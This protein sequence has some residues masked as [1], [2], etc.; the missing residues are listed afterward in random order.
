M[1]LAP[2]W[3]MAELSKRNIS[4]TGQLRL[5][6]GGVRR[7]LAHDPSQQ[8]SSILPRITRRKS[9]SSRANR[10]FLSSAMFVPRHDS[11]GIAALAGGELADIQ[12]LASS[13]WLRFFS[14]IKITNLP[15]SLASDRCGSRCT[16]RASPLTFPSHLI[17][18]PKCHP[19]T[20]L[21]DRRPWASDSDLDANAAELREA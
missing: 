4:L 14:A 11:S 17:R 8:L 2:L 16:S 12:T 15:L 3:L 5:T 19:R 21:A 7:G 1:A 9:Y 20:N 10:E 13:N 6:K 18:L